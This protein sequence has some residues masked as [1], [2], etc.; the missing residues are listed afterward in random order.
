[1]VQPAISSAV[2]AGTGGV[3]IVHLAEEVA[4][5]VVRRGSAAT[6]VQQAG[7]SVLGQPADV[8][9][10]HG[11][12]ALE[13]Q[14]APTGRAWQAGVGRARRFLSGRGGR[15]REGLTAKARML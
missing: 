14:Q 13:G 9:G 3:G 12:D 4:D 10:E 2:A 11:D 15:R 7:E 1:M 5:E 6:L 8:F